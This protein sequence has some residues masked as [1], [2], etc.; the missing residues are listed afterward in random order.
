MIVRRL[1]LVVTIA[2]LAAVVLVARKAVLPTDAVFSTVSAPW[3]PAA[4]PQGGLYECVVLS[5][6]PRRRGGRGTA[7]NVTV[8]NPADAPLDGRLTVLSVEEVSPGTSRCLRSTRRRST[9]INSSTRRSPPQSS[10]STAVVG[11]SNR[12]RLP[13]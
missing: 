10:R 6:R 9:S 1:M 7:G 4:P 5:R 13:R 11:S 8:F 2:A 12:R 3:M